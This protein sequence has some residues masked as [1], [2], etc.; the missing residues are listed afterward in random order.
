M[1]SEHG[2]S[3]GNVWSCYFGLERL[4]IV[5]HYTPRWS[6]FR[7][8]ELEQTA[9]A[10][11]RQSELSGINPNERNTEFKC[12]YR[13]ANG[14][15]MMMTTADRDVFPLRQR[16]QTFLALMDLYLSPYQ[17]RSSLT[18]PARRQCWTKHLLWLTHYLGSERRLALTSV[19]RICSS[20]SKK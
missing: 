15:L 14:D 8:Q 20:Q 12:V 11:F 13:D 16:R 1:S 6:L 4:F 19:H 17:S 7:L 3:L 9:Y 5:A 10:V 18:Y 2:S